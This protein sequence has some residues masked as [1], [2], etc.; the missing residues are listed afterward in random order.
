MEVYERQRFFLLI[1]FY[2]LTWGLPDAKYYD[3]DGMKPE[4]R[5]AFYKW[6]DTQREKVFN[7]EEELLKY[8]RSDVDILRRCCLNFAQTVKGLCKIN[9]FEDCIIASLCNLIFR[10]MFLKK[11]TIAIIP[12]VGYRKKAN[13]SAVAYRWCRINKV[14]TFN[15]VAMSV[16][17][18]WDLTFWMGVVRK[19]APP[20]SFTGVFTTVVPSAFQQ[21][22]SIRSAV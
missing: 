22:R 13:Q 14:C 7:M 17:D 4:A 8:C 15:T 16:R 10:T 3:P 12:H 1:F 5:E 9:P 18:V 6:Y 21:T 11:E 19:H 2:L 20:T